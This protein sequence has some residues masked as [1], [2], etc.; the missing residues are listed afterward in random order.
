MRFAALLVVGCLSAGAWADV[1]HL[2]DG[3]SVEGEIKRTPDGYVVTSP[4]GKV[5][6]VTTDRVQSLE[7]KKGPAGAD[8]AEQR[9][10]SLQRSVVNLSDA[11]EGVK[12]FKAFIAQNPNTPAA[13]QAQKD[14]IVW[15]QRADQGL[16]KVGD[17]WVTP[18]QLA[19]LKAK[20]QEAADAL[21]PL[22]KA[23]KVNEATP[24]LEK[25]LAASPQ[26]PS[27]LYLRGLLLFKQNQTPEARKAF[28][29]AAAQAPDSGA[30]H[31]DLAVI[32]WRQH[33]QMPALV[34][35]DKAMVAD[36]QNQTILD[37]VAEALNALAPDHR[38][39]AVTR[40]IV[41]RFK[42]QDAALQ[43]TMAEKGLYRWGS[44]WLPE[45]EFS[46]IQKAEQDV[47]EKQQKMQKDMTDAQSRMMQID[48]GINDDTNLLNAIR[49]ESM[50]QDAN[51]RLVQY[52]LPQRYYDL[53]RD[54]N[55]LKAEKVL[56][57]RELQQL[58]KMFVD[59]EKFKPAPKY[60]GT[61]KMIDV[62]GM[63]GGSPGNLPSTRPSSESASGLP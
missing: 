22:V 50:Q 11:K 17:Q 44:E 40:K 26:N 30:T 62:E 21:R 18:E 31:N 53:M 15:Q 43:R 59:Q 4:D 7:V 41:D 24:A 2:T 42:E 10:G 8:T 63:P 33:A 39:N 35:Y 6:P 32:H 51:G 16:T 48:R 25:A 13:Q 1:V 56:K 12:R 54:I 5:T 3:T 36:P 57:Q 19:E 9:L 49:Q 46:K 45:K 23:G 14:L 55:S 60:S 38:K 20:A 27:L 28:E 61:Q 47:K 29:N 52:P 58:Q 34:E 37:N